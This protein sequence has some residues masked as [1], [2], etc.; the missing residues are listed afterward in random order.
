MQKSEFFDNLRVADAGW[1][2]FNSWI[3]RILMAPRPQMGK[4]GM[5]NRAGAVDVLLPAIIAPA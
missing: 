2:C 5:Q 1:P 3:S 4:C